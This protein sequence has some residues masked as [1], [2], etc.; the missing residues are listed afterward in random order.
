ME[1]TTESVYYL[2]VLQ[3]AGELPLRHIFPV[4]FS[5]KTAQNNNKLTSFFSFS[6]SVSVSVSVSLSL[7]LCKSKE[8]K[9]K[10]FS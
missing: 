4:E 8:S 7:S 3:S 5:F 10:T 9:G 1:E 6:V 2:Q